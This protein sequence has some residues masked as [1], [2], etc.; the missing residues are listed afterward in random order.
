MFEKK[1]T[2]NEYKEALSLVVNYKKQNESINKLIDHLIPKGRL[3][4]LSG[5]ISDSMFMVL[6]TYYQFHYQLVINKSD[7]SQMHANLLAAIDYKLLKKFRG[8]GNLGILRLQKII[9]YNLEQLD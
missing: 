5:K 7:L 2:F 8:I 6:A 9:E 4:N 1:I 3:I